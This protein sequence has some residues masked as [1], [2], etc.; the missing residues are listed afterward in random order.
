MCYHHGMVVDYDESLSMYM[1]EMHPSVAEENRGQAC[2]MPELQTASVGHP[3]KDSRTKQCANCRQIKPVVRFPT[4]TDKSNRRVY[5][6]WCKDCKRIGNARMRY[7]LS[8]A[9]FTDLFAQ[10]S[11]CHVCKATSR[12][13]IDHCHKTGTVRGLLCAR[14]NKLAAHFEDFD[15]DPDAYLRSLLAY[16]RGNHLNITPAK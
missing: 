10:G 4:Q 9:Q 14:C 7:G 1:F 15:E 6:S 11:F 2:E 12:M 16:L 13:E 5:S 8:P 3:S